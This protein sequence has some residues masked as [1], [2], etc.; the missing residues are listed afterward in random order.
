MIDKVGG[1]ACLL[2]LLKFLA[3]VY[4]LYKIND[5]DAGWALLSPNTLARFEALLPFYKDVP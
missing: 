3:H 2:L 5:K 4:L 1:I